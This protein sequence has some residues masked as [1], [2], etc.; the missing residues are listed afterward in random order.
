[1]TGIVFCLLL[2]VLA[3]A[4]FVSVEISGQLGAE[5]PT[6]AEEV[7]PLRVVCAAASASWVAW[8]AWGRVCLEN[9]WRRGSLG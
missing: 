2:L 3:M 5:D 6:V 4:V 1:M 8:R 9:L 7:E